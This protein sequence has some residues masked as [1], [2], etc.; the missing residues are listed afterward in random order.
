[1]SLLNLYFTLL[2]YVLPSSYL[3]YLA[4]TAKDVVAKRALTS[5]QAQR[6]AGDHLAGC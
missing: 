4:T 5:T 6:P 2:W 3:F 1:M